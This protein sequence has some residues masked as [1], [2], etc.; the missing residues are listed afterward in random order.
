MRRRGFTLVELLVVIA[1]IAVLL[2]ILLPAL[3]SVKEK[4]K[5]MRC[6]HNL[7]G[8]AKAVTFYSDDYGGKLL[9]LR[10]PDDNKIED[11]AYAVYIA[12]AQFNKPGTNQS[13]PFR[14]AC[15]YE[16]GIIQNPRTFYCPAGTDAGYQFE[17]YIDPLPWGSL[18]QTSNTAAG[19]NQW[20]RTG[21]IYR[22]FNKVY[23]PGV[24]YDQGTWGYAEK[25][26]DVNYNKAWLTDSLLKRRSLN[27]VTGNQDRALGIYAAF[28]DTHVNFCTNKEIFSDEYW[29]DDNTDLHPGT[30]QFCKVISLITP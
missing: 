14:L 11:H 27:H 28:P 17:D 23:T 26:V 30:W 15:L 12:G 24:P 3:S 20:V 10:R 8:L 13:M 2:A 4:A 1:I 7:S 22:P 16:T 29:K 19:S 25:L 9:N 6:G 21:Y 18:P 5:R